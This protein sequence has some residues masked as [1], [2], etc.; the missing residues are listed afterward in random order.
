MSSNEYNA[1]LGQ[2][3]SCSGHATHF[4]EFRDPPN[5]SRTVEGRNIKFGTNTDGSEFQR[6]KCKIRSKGVMWGSR[7]PLLE[8]WHF[9]L[10][11]EGL[12][13]FI[14]AVLSKLFEMEILHRFNK[15]FTTSHAQF[16]FKKK[17]SCSHVIY[18][19][20]NVV[21]HCYI[22]GDSTVNLAMVDLSKAFDKMNHHALFQK[23]LNT[24]F[25][26]S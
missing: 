24:K 1:K 5:I 14:N 20:R 8:F 17:L 15:Y 4:L 18:S 13:L 23:L 10:S 19:V 2:E 16:G 22:N 21:N 25:P 12:K 6:I 7:D 26:F 9:L 11:P 3:G